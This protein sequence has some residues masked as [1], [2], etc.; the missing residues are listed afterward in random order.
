MF[1]FEILYPWWNVPKLEIRFIPVFAG[2]EQRRSFHDTLLPRW[3]WWMAFHVLPTSARKYIKNSLYQKFF[4]PSDLFR[5]KYETTL[6]R[7]YIK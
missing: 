5:Y 4:L 2:I 6:E 1:A 7:P 3:L